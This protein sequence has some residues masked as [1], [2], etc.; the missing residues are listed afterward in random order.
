MACLHWLRK[1]AHNTLVISVYLVVVTCLFDCRNAVAS[2]TD[3]TV[4]ISSSDLFP[5]AVAMLTVTP[6]DRVSTASCIWYNQ[7]YTLF[8]LKNKNAFATF[9]PVGLRKKT[10]TLD[11]PVTVHTTYGN[12]VTQNIPVT[13][14][15]K[16]YPVQHLT[17]PES[18][19]TLS[20]KDLA[21]HNREK[22]ELAAALSEKSAAKIW[23]DNFIMP[24]KGSISTPFGVRRFLNKKPRNSHSGID[25]RAKQGHPIAASSD[26]RVIYTGDHFFSGNSVYIDH[27]MG[28]MTMY[29]HMSKIDVKRG[30]TVSRGDIIGLVGSTG[31][32]TGPHLHWG[33]KINDHRIDPLTFLD[34]FNPSQEQ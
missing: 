24:L 21:R 30:Q 26:G 19:V 11:L 34:L 4:G 17:L 28:I 8:P 13:I 9:I 6:M 31:R 5:G 22:K 2:Q 7:S 25:L 23:L 14:S 33:I 3:I 10:G 1:C 20:K 12:T 18:K 29:F 15:K 32:S 27:G 16:D